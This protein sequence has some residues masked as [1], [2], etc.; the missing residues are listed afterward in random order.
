MNVLDVNSP[1][2]EPRL[3]LGRPQKGRPIFRAPRQTT[4][5]QKELFW[6]NCGGIVF[7]ATRRRFLFCH[8]VQ[9]EM[10]VLPKTA[11]ATAF[12]PSANLVPFTANVLLQ[13]MTYIV[14]F[15]TMRSHWNVY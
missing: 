11:A 2:S 6:K 10:M 8:W 7:D 13:A 14:S 4:R 3:A 9:T 1:V 12:F 15:G 5:K